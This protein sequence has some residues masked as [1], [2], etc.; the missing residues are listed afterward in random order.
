MACVTLLIAA[1]DNETWDLL[2]LVQKVFW[3]L[4]E[5]KKKTI[6]KKFKQV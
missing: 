6:R 1:K 4:K 5:E 3:N 2:L